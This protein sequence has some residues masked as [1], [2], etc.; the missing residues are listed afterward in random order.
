MFSNVWYFSKYIVSQCAAGLGVIFAKYSVIA[1]LFGSK[2]L[3][4]KTSPLSFGNCGAVTAPI[5]RDWR[6]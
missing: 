1:Q 5:L 3:N 2:E 4:K 6:E